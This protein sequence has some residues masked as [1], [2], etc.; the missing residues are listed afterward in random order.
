M[1]GKAMLPLLLGAGALAL[2]MSKKKNGNG[3]KAGVVSEGVMYSSMNLP[4]YWRVES[5]AGGM[6]GF[7][8]DVHFSAQHRSMRA[9]AGGATGGWIEVGT[10]QSAEAAEDAA[11]SHVVGLG[12]D[13]EELPVPG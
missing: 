13:K 2:F 7:G 3:A 12:F 10:Y 9:A 6:P 1:A 5:K 8:G 11:L 4:H